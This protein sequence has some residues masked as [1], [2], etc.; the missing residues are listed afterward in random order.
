MVTLLRANKVVSDNRPRDAM[1]P[2]ERH[3]AWM[4]QLKNSPYRD[5]YTNAE[6]FMD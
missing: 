6:D 4:E 3:R 5:F 2:E 1:T